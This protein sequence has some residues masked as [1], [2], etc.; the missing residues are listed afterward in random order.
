MKTGKH[1]ASRRDEEKA[2]SP[3]GGLFATAR[4]NMIAKQIYRTRLHPV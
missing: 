2:A 1:A 4:Q 3:E